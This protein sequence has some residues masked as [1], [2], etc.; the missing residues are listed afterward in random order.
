MYFEDETTFVVVNDNAIFC[1]CH[2][3][4]R[5]RLRDRLCKRLRKEK[6]AVEKKDVDLIA[7][8]LFALQLLRHDCKQRHLS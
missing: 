7:H 2:T 4:L 8:R 5:D 6:L 3:N 1:F